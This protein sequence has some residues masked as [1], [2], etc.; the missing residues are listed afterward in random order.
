MPISTKKLA[1]WCFEYSWILLFYQYKFLCTGKRRGLQANEIGAVCHVVG[2]NFY[3]V[4]PDGVEF[5][6]GYLAYHF[7]C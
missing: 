4:L 7:A 1:V 5:V 2:V 6:F 3:L